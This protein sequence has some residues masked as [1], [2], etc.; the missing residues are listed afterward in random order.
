MNAI[1]AAGL[2]KKYAECQECGNANVNN[3]EGSLLI[4]DDVFK[5]ECK[6]GWSIEI[7]ENGQHVN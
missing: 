5:R 1:K 4:T 7:K 2:I 3:G 6:C